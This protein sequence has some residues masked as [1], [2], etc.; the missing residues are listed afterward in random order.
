M[1]IRTMTQA[2]LEVALGWARAEGWNPGLEDAHTFHAADPGGFL[3]GWVDGKPVGSISAVD[4]VT[5]FGFIGLYIMSPDFRGQGLGMQLW[6]AAMERLKD[7][8]VGLDGVVAQQ[9][10]Y[11]KSGFKLAHRSLRFEAEAPRLGGPPFSP[12]P[13]SFEQLLALAT[14]V[15]PAGRP[16]Y[17]QAWLNQ[18]QARVLSGP[19]CLVVARPCHTGHKI[20]PL[21]APDALI[22]RQ[23]LETICAD[24]SGPIFLDVPESNT[25]AMQMVRELG[26]TAQFECARMYT[27][28]VPAFAVD[29]WFG[30][31]TFELG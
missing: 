28:E 23:L 30:V 4:W 5:G 11:A 21:I 25:A 22:A 2:D 13:A 19:D 15:S 18:K 24:L 12:Q 9:G 20:G 7:C 14:A 17:L 29:R 10:N 8:L 31:T 3:M 26:M 16:A 6:R 1:E 27:G